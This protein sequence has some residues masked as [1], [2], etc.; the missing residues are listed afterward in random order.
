MC[1]FFHGSLAWARI[2]ATTGG[3][4]WEDALRLVG[5]AG[6]GERANTQQGNTEGKEEHQQAKQQ[7]ITTTAR[8]TKN[9]PKTPTQTTTRSKQNSKQQGTY[10]VYM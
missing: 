1:V 3:F 8:F 4:D 2:Q 7:T 10:I 5:Q 9:N 6:Q